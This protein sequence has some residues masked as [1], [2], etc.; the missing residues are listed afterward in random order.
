MGQVKGVS[1]SLS[2]AP[3]SRP[4]LKYPSMQ[5]ESNA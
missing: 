5:S 4:L 3:H 2:R 1:L